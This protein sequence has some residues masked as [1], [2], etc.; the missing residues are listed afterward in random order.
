MSKQYNKV[1]TGFVIQ[2]YKKV[3]GRFVCVGQEFTAGDQVDREDEYGDIIGHIPVAQEVYQSFDMIQPVN[4]EDH[5]IRLDEFN[6][7]VSLVDARIHDGEI[8]WGGSIVSGLQEKCPGCGMVDVTDCICTERVEDQD[9]MYDRERYNE[10]MHSIESLILSHACAG[11]NIESKEY[12]QGIQNTLDSI[13]NN[14]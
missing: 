13:G 11:V 6:I 3:D 12:R 14:I 2:E 7:E 4:L 9:D 1:T 10:L 5:T 8:L